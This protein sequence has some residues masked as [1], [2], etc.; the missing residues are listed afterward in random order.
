MKNR[1]SKFLNKIVQPNCA[2]EQSDDEIEQEETQSSLTKDDLG[3]FQQELRRGLK[4]AADSY[5]YTSK[6]ASQLDD[7]TEY[8]L[9]RYELGKALAR[10][11]EFRKQYVTQE[12]ARRSR[13]E[14]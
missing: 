12:L 5:L 3:K 6:S 9:L 4:D 2:I 1:E 13:L 8:E 10:S 11:P 7:D 14:N